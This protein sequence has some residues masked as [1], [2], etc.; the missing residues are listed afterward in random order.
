MAGTLHTREMPTARNT[1]RGGRRLGSTTTESDCPSRMFDMTA[2]LSEE[3]TS[4]SLGGCGV[5]RR[6]KHKPCK[7]ES[8]ASSAS[9]PSSEAIS[10]DNH[11]PRYR[12]NHHHHHRRQ[13][14]AAS[15]QSL[16]TLSTHSMYTS[17]TSDGSS[18][19]DSSRYCAR[20]AKTSGSD[21]ELSTS[22]GAT[23]SSLMSMPE[24][25]SEISTFGICKKENSLSSI[26]SDDTSKTPH[27]GRDCLVF[28]PKD[29]TK[30]NKPVPKST[31]PASG[32][33][34]HTRPTGYTTR[35]KAPPH[36]EPDDEKPRCAER[37]PPVPEPV[38]GCAYPGV[39]GTVVLYERFSKFRLLNPR[40]LVLYD[41]LAER[42]P[43]EAD[44]SSSLLGSVRHGL[45]GASGG[46]RVGNHGE[47]PANDKAER[48]HP[49]AAVSRMRYVLM[50][51]NDDGGI[52]ADNAVVNNEDPDFV[53]LRSMPF[54]NTVPPAGQ[55]YDDCCYGPSSDGYKDHYKFVVLS[56][57][58]FR[59]SSAF[60][61]YFSASVSV[62]TERTEEH[63]FRHH[64][65]EVRDPQDDFRLATAGVALIDPETGVFAKLV[66]TNKSIYALYGVS[67]GQP[68]GA[69]FMSAVRIGTRDE[70]CP[71]EDFH[72]VGIGYDAGRHMMRWYLNGNE[73][74][75][76]L[77]IGHRPA[78]IRAEMVLDDGRSH[79]SVAPKQ[80]CISFGTYTFL[81]A[82]RT[83]GGWSRPLVRL[84]G[85]YGAY[86]HPR[87]VDPVTS[88][89]ICDETFVDDNCSPDHR[90][91]G[92]GATLR[93][94]YLRL[95]YRRSFGGQ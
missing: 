31:S 41:P 5:L 33:K 39:L 50:G 28:N 10:S 85:G 57:Y 83:D 48:S 75:R 24:P 46:H 92:Q 16:P 59:A 55:T 68:T 42:P 25:I 3:T 79:C 90:L 63:P 32:K 94:R 18:D 86:A 53:E 93:M 12:H 8:A 36:R 70:R 9:N 52:L 77:Q 64:A 11:R 51:S 60:E 88:E 17:S 58:A 73:A 89:P 81:D 78:D 21:S 27:G 29:M 45:C 22:P 74:W 38:S 26:S 69:S 37:L 40:N 62:I 44:S 61:M 47:I 1:H 84:I 91:W 43:L 14:P 13:R 49:A 71:A 56:E 95:T 67:P 15:T 6:G 82:H 72:D 54:I 87:Q 4:M 2:S 66:M 23:M 7:K 20:R 65:S 76:V 30:S 34:V 80:L 19:E 35:S